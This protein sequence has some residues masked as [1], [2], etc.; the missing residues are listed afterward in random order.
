[1]RSIKKKLPLPLLTMSALVAGRSTIAA[2]HERHSIYSAGEPGDPKKPSRTIEIAMSEMAFDP[3]K[4]EV[5]RGEQIRFVL[6]NVGTEQPKSF[7]SLRR[8]EHSNIRV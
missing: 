5:K 1:M 7:G 6:R 2:A 4:I 3:Y 8:Q